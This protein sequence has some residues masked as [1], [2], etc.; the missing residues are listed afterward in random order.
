MDN[1]TDTDGRALET[2]RSAPDVFTIGRAEVSPIPEHVR[3]LVAPAEWT[4]YEWTEYQVSFTDTTH[5]R[6]GSQIVG[7]TFATGDGLSHFRLRFE[8][9]LGYTTLQPLAGGKRSAPVLHIEVLAR[10][11]PSIDHSLAFMNGLLTDLFAR[12][13]TLPFSVSRRTTRTIQDEQ[14]APN[15]LFAF[16][17]FRHHHEEL[18]RAVQAVLGAPHRVLSDR[19]EHVRVH[20]VKRIDNEA[21]LHMLR[22][23]SRG[24]GSPQPPGA[25]PLHRLQPERVL[26]R[27]PEETFDTP[28]NRYILSIAR[29]MFITMRRI[30]QAS[31]FPYVRDGGIVTDIPQTFDRLEHHFR[32]LVTDRR[33]TGLDDPVVVPSQSRVLQNK[34]GYRDLTWLWDAFHRHQ[35]PVYERMQRA[36]D[37]RDVPTLYEFWLLFELIDGIREYTGIAPRM[38]DFNDVNQ[39]KWAFEARF[40]GAGRLIYQPSYSAGDIYSGIRAR[41]DY[42]WEREDGRRIVMDAKFAL[43]YSPMSGAG[44]DEQLEGESWAVTSNIGV[45]HGYRDAIRNTSAAIVLFPGNRGDFRSPNGD[46]IKV[47]ALSDLLPKIVEASLS[48]VGAIPMSPVHQRSIEGTV[49]G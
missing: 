7:P 26:Q 13:A 37:L 20:E 24:A 34:D 49:R 12:G 9:E 5:L 6:I 35:Q 27:I 29:R 39:S 44:G 36:I 19:V 38:A 45:M 22:V 40:P 18:I 8:N 28:E 46:R 4:I 2:S 31:W 14:R 23:P 47:R 15:D 30:R 10:K 21:L 32:Q 25:S 42:V 17:F 33:F 3:R 48:G 11:F 16:H 43:S 41:P 1:Q